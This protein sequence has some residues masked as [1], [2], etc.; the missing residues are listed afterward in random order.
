MNI[1]IV[2]DEKLAIDVLTIMV[3]QLA[4][5]QINI[6]GTFTNSTE[7]LQFLE[8]E[9]IDVVFLDIEMID[10]HGMQLAKL[11]L[12][13]QPSLQI[14]FVT[15]HTQ[16]AVEAF[17]VEATDYLLKPVHEK[18]LIIALTKAQKNGRYGGAEG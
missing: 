10:T 9:I 6:K 16:F 7:A 3:K 1:M 14:I 8:K 12:H 13:K 11:L 18:R 2:D 15:A 4:Q 5:F 17:E